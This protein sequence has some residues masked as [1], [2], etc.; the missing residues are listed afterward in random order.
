MVAKYTRVACTRARY[1]GRS[2]SNWNYAI[3][4]HNG[5]TIMYQASDQL[6]RNECNGDNTRPRLFS[7]LL[8]R[9]HPRYSRILVNNNYPTRVIR[10]N[11]QG[12]K[13]ISIF[14]QSPPLPNFKI[15]YHSI[16]AT[17][18][19]ATSLQNNSVEITK[20]YYHYSS[21][22]LLIDYRLN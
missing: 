1:T 11:V 14:F 2:L 4:W 10:S 7:C 3:K 20:H 8:Q 16:S 13:I 12:L 21:S 19:N 22:F 15:I 5:S 17:I 9:W 6:G 18:N